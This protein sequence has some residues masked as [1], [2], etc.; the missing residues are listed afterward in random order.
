VRGTAIVA[1]V[2]AVIIG[3]G[4]LVIGV[5]LV[6]PLAILTFLGAFLPLVGAVLAGLVAALVALVDGGITDALLVTG[7]IV[8]VQQV[9][10]DVLA[11]LVLGRAVKLHPLVILVT[12]TAGAVI[13]G[14][15]GAFLAVPVTAVVVAVG[16]ELRA[17]GVIGPDRP[18]ALGPEPVSAPEDPG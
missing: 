13:G 14:L 10:G 6:L 17:R 5:P 4:L 3:I 8:V 15:V 11:P 1:L 12:L 9:E 2:D 16:A 18:V 7:V